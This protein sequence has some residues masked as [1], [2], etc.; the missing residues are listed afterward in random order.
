MKIKWL[1]ASAFLITTENGTKIVTDP[2]VQDFEPEVTPDIE[3]EGNYMLSRN[4]IEEAA[5]IVIITHGH[6]DHCWVYPLKGNPGPFQ[7]YMGPEPAEINGIKM[8][9]VITQHGARRGLNTVI[10]ME[11]DGLKLVHLGDIGHAF[12]EEQLAQVGEAD[13]LMTPWD[14][15]EATLPFEHLE[16]ILGQLKPKVIFPMHHVFVDD[17]LTSKENV[18]TLD[19]T[20]I[21]FTK[22]T[23]PA[24]PHI[25]MLKAAYKI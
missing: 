2:Y 9:G 14:D 8:H 16:V 23:L 15:M 6:F 5:N 7:V 17:Y 1:G 18:I 10:C 22:D 13:I 11:I 3:G 19:A 21:E 20:D 4:T 25:Y 12:T 24:A